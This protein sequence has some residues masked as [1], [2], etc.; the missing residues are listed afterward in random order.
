MYLLKVLR[1]KEMPRLQHK[2]MWHSAACSE[3]VWDSA[4]GSVRWSGAVQYRAWQWCG[5]RRYA[6]WKVL[7]GGMKW[8]DGP[9]H[10]SGG[11]ASVPLAHGCL[12]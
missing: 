8:S 6:R 1:F 2:A 9:H 11:R 10:L 5:V 12:G 4:V 3:W 7:D